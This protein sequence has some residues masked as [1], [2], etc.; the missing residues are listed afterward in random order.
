[1]LDDATLLY[2]HLWDRQLLFYITVGGGIF[3]GARACVPRIDEAV[4]V[5]EP[6]MMK[7]ASHTHF[8]PTGNG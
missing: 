4:Y 1:M 2:V 5:P 7:I 8:F 6:T 3:A